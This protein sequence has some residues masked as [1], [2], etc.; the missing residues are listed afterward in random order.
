MVTNLG[1]QP[2]VN[3]SLIDDAAT[4]SDPSDDVAPT[5]LSGDSNNNGELDPGEAWV[6]EWLAVAIAGEQENRAVAAADDVFGQLAE[7]DDLS[8]YLGLEPIQPQALP[9]VLTKRRFLWP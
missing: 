1:N 3:V 7:D 8:R 9:G 4:P 2:L 5:L 6:Y